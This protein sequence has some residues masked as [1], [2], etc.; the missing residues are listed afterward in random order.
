VSVP[1]A[2]YIDVHVPMAVTESLRRKGLD[3]L[4]S[5]DDGT[6]TQDDEVLLARANELGRVLF[7]QDQDFLRIT[8][9]W[10]RTGRPFVGVLFAA[11]Q[12][13]SLGRLADDLELLLTC[14]EPEELRD[15]VTYLPLR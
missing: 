6:A 5:Q 1:L 11:Q 3:I 14:C 2:L 4:T 7:S 8:A 15:R 12:G 9:E 13:V 10:Q